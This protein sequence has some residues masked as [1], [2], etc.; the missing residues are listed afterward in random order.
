MLISLA[1]FADVVTE[2]EEYVWKSKAEPIDYKCVPDKEVGI[3]WA[4]SGDDHKLTTFLPSGHD[5]FFLTHISNIPIKALP[6]S[7][8]TINERKFIL[9][10]THYED[11]SYLDVITESNSYFL[12]TQTED[13]SSFKTY[14]KSK[15]EYSNNRGISHIIKCSARHNF[16]LDL[17]TMRFV[18]SYLGTWHHSTK[19]SDYSGNSAV[20]SYGQCR[21]YFR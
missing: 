16:E 10:K 5:E 6:A 12:R 21:K 9:E 4:L 3:D 2:S 18:S 7:S 19:P 15:C 1:G 14:L 11:S 20:L 8:L 17:D 13:P